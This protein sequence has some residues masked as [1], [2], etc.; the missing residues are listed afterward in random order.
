MTKHR[1][2][3]KR[4]MTGQADADIAFNDLCSMLERLGFQVR[5]RGSHYIF[6]KDG[7]EE[8]INLQPVGIL[9]KPYQVKQVRNLLRSHRLDKEK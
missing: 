9:A 4:L 6:T 8:L 2:F 3:L 5:V 7:V 1:K